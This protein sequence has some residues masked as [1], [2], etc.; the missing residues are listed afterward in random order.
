MKKRTHAKAR[1]KQDLAAALSDRNTR[2]EAIAQ[3]KKLGY[4]AE[5]FLPYLLTTLEEW[6]ASNSGNSGESHHYAWQA[7]SDAV[8]KMEDAEFYR[9]LIIT[10]GQSGSRVEKAISALIRALDHENAIIRGAA[11]SALARVGLPAGAAI[12]ALLRVLSE[13]TGEYVRQIA[14]RAL[15]AID[16]E[17]RRIIQPL[18]DALKDKSPGV[19]RYA[20]EALGNTRPAPETAMRLAGALTDSSPGVLISVAKSL[21]KFGRTALVA[22]PALEKASVTTFVSVR[23]AAVSALHRIGA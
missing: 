23:E 5:E 3:I 9:S 17:D 11:A 22:A 4:E 8:E 18:A 20:A 15:S 7:G 12:P 1:R 6:L 14:A 2:T 19:R 16:P 13:D 10:L 21:G